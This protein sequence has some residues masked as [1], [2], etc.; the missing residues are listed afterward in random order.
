MDRKIRNIC[1]TMLLEDNC[2]PDELIPALKIG[3]IHETPGMQNEEPIHAAA[4]HNS[5]T[6][7]IDLLLMHGAD[8][9][10][11]DEYKETP[12]FYAVKGKY[13]EIMIP[14][15]IANGADIEARNDFG[16]TPLLTALDWLDDPLPVVTILKA[17]GCDLK[18][19]DDQGKGV[20]DY[21]NPELFPALLAVC[22]E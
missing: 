19:L 12:L 10:A 3:N 4:W 16:Q 21:I 8:I 1:L 17:H 18:A 9:N 14:H 6:E 7:N 11:K 15:L 2:T 13:P 5:H 22:K 20:L